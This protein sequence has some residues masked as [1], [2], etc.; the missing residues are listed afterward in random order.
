MLLEKNVKNKW[1]DSIINNEVFQRAKG[2][3]LL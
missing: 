3:R 2:E 1:T